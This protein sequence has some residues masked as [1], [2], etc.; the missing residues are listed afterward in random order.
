MYVPS[1]ASKL[2][3]FASE[4]VIAAKKYAISGAWDDTRYLL[5]FSQALSRR[6][7]FSQS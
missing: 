5:W 3:L 6:Q 2:N 1:L 7:A 4:V